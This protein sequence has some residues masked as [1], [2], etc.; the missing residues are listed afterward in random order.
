MSETTPT[1][2]PAPA[3]PGAPATPATPATAATPAL[4]ATPRTPRTPRPIALRVLGVWLTVLAVLAGTSAAA[5]ATAGKRPHPRHGGTAPVSLVGVWDL[6]VTV[7]TPDGGVST[8]PTRFTFRA[9]HQLTGDGPLDANGQ[10][11]FTE[12][13]F[14]NAKP[15]GTF[16]LYITH[17]S[18]E[19]GAIPGVVQAV[20]MGKISGKTLTT[21][22]YA[23]VTTD[24]GQAP[25]GPIDVDS[26]GT[27]V[28][29]VPAS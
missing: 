2:A 21:V 10:P 23:F 5:A 20:H 16:A 13:G 28:S 19:G 8:N 17:G 25:L 15:D 3:R 12:T 29:A 11:L 24:P 26:T 7:H 27:W 22:A 14:W 6:M 1:P 4:L 9:D 18:V